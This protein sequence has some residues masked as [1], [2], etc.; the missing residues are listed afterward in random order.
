MRGWLMGKAVSIYGGS[1][2]IQKNI[3]AKN[4]LGLPENTQRG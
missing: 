4:I 1:A 3:I 2:E